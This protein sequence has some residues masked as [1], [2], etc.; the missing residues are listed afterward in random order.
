[1][2][3]NYLKGAAI[4]RGEVIARIS[5]IRKFKD[6]KFS[7]RHTWGYQKSLFEAMGFFTGNSFYIIL[8]YNIM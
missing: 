4:P 6:G 1:M 8:F 7:L 3:V 5:Y 2:L